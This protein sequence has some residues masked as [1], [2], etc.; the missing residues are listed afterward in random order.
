MKKKKKLKKKY[1]EKQNKKSNG[2][3]RVWK[4]IPKMNI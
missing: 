3:D 2:Y 4:K 1:K